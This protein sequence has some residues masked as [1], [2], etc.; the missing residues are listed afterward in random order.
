M[1]RKQGFRKTIRRYPGVGWIIE[2]DKIYGQT[3]YDVKPLPHKAGHLVHSF[4]KRKKALRFGRKHFY[5][6]QL[7]L[8]RARKEAVD[9]YDYLINGKLTVTTSDAGTSE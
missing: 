4:R 5:L 2:R 6:N 3:V 7:D 8:D 1:A 9:L